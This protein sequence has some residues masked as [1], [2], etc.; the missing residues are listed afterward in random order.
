MHL[1]LLLKIFGYKF[2]WLDVI[3]ITLVL[4]LVY[5]FYRRVRGSLGL[6]IFLG[7]IL[8]YLIYKLVK[9]VH[10]DI[11]S[12]ILGAFVSAGVVAMLVVFQPEIRKFLLSLGDISISE[13]MNLPFKL[14]ISK[15]QKTR[16]EERLV[17]EMLAAMDNLSKTKTGALLVFNNHFKLHDLTNPGVALHALVSEKLLE[18]IFNKYSPLHDGAVIIVNNRIIFAGSVLPVSDS[19]DLPPRAGLRHRSAVGI[20]EHSEAVAIV[21]SEETGNISYA[22]NGKIRTNLPLVEVKQLLTDIVTDRV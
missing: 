9:W 20:T 18:S 2:E 15:R 10:L 6:N 7:M 17:G 21:V 12:E 5:Q 19:P 11:L 1:I 13:K 16:E 4:I 8:I 14:N 22:K 3:D